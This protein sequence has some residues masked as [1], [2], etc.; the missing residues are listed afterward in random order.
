MG[1]ISVTLL[2]MRKR[3]EEVEMHQKNKWKRDAQQLSVLRHCLNEKI[4]ENHKIRSS[5]SSPGQSLKHNGE[6]KQALGN[7]ALESTGTNI[8]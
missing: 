7:K 5:P 2:L 1:Q 8:Q 3:D 6:P 4:N